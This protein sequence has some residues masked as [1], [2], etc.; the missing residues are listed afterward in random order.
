M[1][2]VEEAEASSH[3]LSSIGEEDNNAHDDWREDMHAASQ[4]LTDNPTSSGWTAPDAT[5]FKPISKRRRPRGGKKRSAARNK[6][7]AAAKQ[8][9]QSN[10]QTDAPAASSENKGDSTSFAPSS[11]APTQFQPHPTRRSSLV[12]S[13]SF[14]SGPMTGSTITPMSIT[15]SASYPSTRS[16]SRS[17]GDG[18]MQPLSQ[19]TSTPP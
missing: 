12:A 18:L 17:P 15:P 8:A 13:G 14:H 11:S 16:T 19:T 5:L 4:K 9:A 3:G 7:T 6:R 10:G 1:E 2:D